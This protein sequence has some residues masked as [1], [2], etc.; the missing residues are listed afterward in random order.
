[1]PK[2][3]YRNKW[4][5]MGDE[6][7]AYTGI[8]VFGQ[9]CWVD[10]AASMVIAKFA[11][12]P[13]PTDE[14]VDGD[15]IRCFQAIGRE[16]GALTLT[17]RDLTVA[18]AGWF[19]ALN[20]AAVPHVNA[21][22]Q[23]DLAALLAEARLARAVEVDG[24]P[25]AGLIAFAAGAAY[26]SPNYRWFDARSDGFL[27]IDRIVVDE[28]RRGGGLGLALYRDVVAAADGRYRCLAC[29]VNERPANEASMRFHE[30]FGFRAVGRQQT[31]GGAKSVVLME[32]ALP[33][34]TEE[35]P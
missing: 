9:M 16:L 31:E 34:T 22:T 11:S 8:G 4:W 5:I 25:A 35:R 21:L 23:G 15:T 17:L 28:A 20:N 2:G 10:P 7:G 30:R 27:Y 12:Q 1:M 26:A 3:S 14:A 29:E 6:H 13:L 33:A 18:D 19:L 24:M 32:R